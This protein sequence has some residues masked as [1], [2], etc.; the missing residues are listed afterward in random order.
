VTFYAEWREP[1]EPGFNVVAGPGEGLARLLVITGRLHADDY[2]HVH[3]HGG[4]E[5]LVVRRG[6]L[7]VRVGDER[8]TCRAGDVV[9]V[10]PHTPHGFH[11]YTE[12]MLEVIAEQGIGTYYPTREPDGARRY[13]AAFRPNLPWSPPPPNGEW[14]SDDDYQRILE[15]IDVPV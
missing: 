10:P 12:T 7:V 11:A 9:V 14:T 6:E 15:A 2:G 4:E 13:V 5:V 3:L 1:E 8:R